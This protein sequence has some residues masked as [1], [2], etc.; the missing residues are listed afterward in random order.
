M[1]L[2][3]V[4]A[5]LALAAL[6]WIALAQQQEQAFTNR[7]TAL[8]E[9]GSPDS[10]TLATLPEN[11]PVKVF[12]RGGGWARVEAGGQAGS[13]NVFHLRYPAVAQ[14]TSSGSGL[15]DLASAAGLG[16]GNQKATTS[17]L[18]IR[19]LDKVA[20]QNATPDS[21]ELRRLQ[22]LRVDQPGAERFARDGK[23]NAV[24]VDYE[25]GSRR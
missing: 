24:P 18:G 11:T 10:R 22:S 12:S 2:R 6:S 9:Q 13:V 1:N 19:G 17:S 5:T 25:G 20:V 14:T 21:E 7:S 3:P 4:V 16:K 23:L 8:K 15:A